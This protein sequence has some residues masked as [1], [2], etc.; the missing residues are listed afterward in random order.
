MLS[1]CLATYNGERFIKEQIESI[2]CQ[3]DAE[4]EL[5]IS[6]DHSMDN[7]ISIIHTIQ[8]SRIVLLENKSRNGVI[9]NFENAISKAKGEY[10]FLSDQDDVWL[11]LKVKNTISKIKSIEE[12]NTKDKPILVFSDAIV[13]DENLHVLIPSVFGH[14]KENPDIS[15]TPDIL[16]VANRMLGCTMAFN[17]KA[18]EI[19]L[20]IAS[21]AVMHDWWI[22]LSVSKQGIIEP[23][24]QKTV[25]Y[26][27]HNNNVI[28]AKSLQ[29]E[30]K[31]LRLR[32]L[33]A[34]NRRIYK[35]SSLFFPIT[36]F[37]FIR[38]K[39]KLHTK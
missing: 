27:Q 14:S 37:Q 17:R 12:R 8:D 4:D 19:S 23:I 26:R 11:P 24:Y 2:L 31:L 30:S 25:L 10:I 34:F 22:A 39:I 15:G 1:V 20:P 28:G 16:S 33:W 18:K 7:T 32:E 13:V 5:I 29:P 21:S 9:G 6:D 36:F 3:I 38:L 35:M